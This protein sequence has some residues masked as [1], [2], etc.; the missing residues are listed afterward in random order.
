MMHRIHSFIL[1]SLLFFGVSCQEDPEEDAVDLMLKSDVDLFENRGDG[2]PEVHAS[3]LTEI[4]GRMLVAGFGGTKEGDDDVGVW[5]TKKNKNGEW[6]KPGIVAKIREDAHW[7][8]VLFSQKN[9]VYLFF[10]VGK[11][12]SHWETW[13]MVSEDEGESWTAPVELV[14]NDKGGRGPVRNKL[15]VLSDGSWIAGASTEFDD[16]V[17]FADISE[18]EGKTW[19]KSKSIEYD[20][21]DFEG[22]GMIQPTLWESEPGKVHMLLRTTEG[23]IYRSDSED[24]GKTW[25]QAYKTDLPNPNSG[26]DVVKAGDKLILA[27][28]PDSENWGSRKDL[29]LAVSEDNGKTWEDVVRVENGGDPE[30]EYSYPA[31]IGMD[32]TVALTYTVNRKSIKYKEFEIKTTNK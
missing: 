9:Y 24:Y 28:N 20:K 14:E 21:S 26:I 23:Y 16:W 1:L 8:P 19:N 22:K 17:S 12:I 11:K 30:D 15:I 5:L 27:Y 6:E 7:N 31:I 10:K 32:S 2:F 29:N 13:W 18:D 3:T 25:S 4:N